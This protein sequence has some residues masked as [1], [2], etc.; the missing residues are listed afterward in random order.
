LELGDYVQLCA[1]ASVVFDY[2]DAEPVGML[3]RL[4]ARHDLRVGWRASPWLAVG[5]GPLELRVE[6]AVRNFYARRVYQLGGVG[7]L[8]ALDFFDFD[9]LIGLGYR[10][11]ALRPHKEKGGTA[12]LEMTP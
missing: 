7:D 6:G 4:N 2:I 1:S 8:V 5:L 11:P 3:E 9:L 12:S 10:S